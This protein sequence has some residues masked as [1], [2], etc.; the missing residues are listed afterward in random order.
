MR[1]VLYA[2]LAAIVF[3][4]LKAF[5]FDDYIEAYKNDDAN[6]SEESNQTVL[7]AQE[8]QETNET[9][10]TLSEQMLEKSNQ[11]EEKKMPID[12]LGD[13]IADKLKDKIK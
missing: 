3:L 9:N 12:E 13:A 2:F 10:G 11:A 7:P 1:P 8:P 6:R 5:I 4:I